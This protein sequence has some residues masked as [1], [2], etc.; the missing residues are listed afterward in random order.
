MDRRTINYVPRPNTLSMVAF[1]EWRQ[2]SDCCRSA[3]VEQSTVSVATIIMPKFKEPEVE[4]EVKFT[5][6]CFEAVILLEY[7]RGGQR[8]YTPALVH[9]LYVY[10]YRTSISD[11]KFRWQLKTFLF[12]I[13][14]P[15]LTVTVCLLRLKKYLHPYLLTYFEWSQLSTASA[16]LQWTW[17]Q[18]TLSAVHRH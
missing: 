15:R 14:W 13:N 12:E 17:S 10:V 11:N 18:E 3:G 1:G 2:E 7:W 4:V 8:G 16:L 5:S 6:N 9:F